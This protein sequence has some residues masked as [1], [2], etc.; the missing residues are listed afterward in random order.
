MAEDVFVDSNFFIALYNGEDALH[1]AAKEVSRRV[2]EEAPRLVTS[3]L[4]FLETVTV[5]SQRT[6]RDVAIEA[7]DGLKF[8][9]TLKL[10]QVDPSMQERSWQIFCEI[11]NKNMSFVD[12]SILALMESLGIESLLTFDRDDF[13]GL[14]ERYGFEFFE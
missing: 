3:D 5:L 7:G 8:S 2:A 1:D 4:I 13:G 10:V 12:C 9:P 14:E 6:G 11:E